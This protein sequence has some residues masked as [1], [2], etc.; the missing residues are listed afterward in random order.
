[1]RNEVEWNDHDK[2]TGTATGDALDAHR[3]LGRLRLAGLLA[4]MDGRTMITDDDWLWGTMWWNTS[5]NLRNYVAE[6]WEA[7]GMA[8][9]TT[10][11]RRDGELSSVKAEAA[12]AANIERLARRIIRY[13][14]EK[15]AEGSPFVCNAAWASR[16]APWLAD[17]KVLAEERGW[18]KFENA[19]C[20]L[21]PNASEVN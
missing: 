4:L 1:M 8:E 10:K 7:H 6:W 13:A 14:K 17:A 11:A 15:A 12:A 21:G 5:A 9:A 20:L 18:V 19:R 2:N 16:D 3:D